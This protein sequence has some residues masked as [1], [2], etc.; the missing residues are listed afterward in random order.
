MDYVMDTLLRSLFELVPFTCARVLVPEGGSW[1]QALGERFYPKPSKKT[2]GSPLHLNSD[3]SLFLQR[4][5]SEQRPLLLSDTKLQQD[6]E[7]FKGH[8]DSRSW[9][10]VPLIASEQYLGFLSIGHTEPNRFTEEHLRRA[11]LLAVPAAAA[12]QNARLYQTAQIYG[13][14]LE[15]RVADLKHAQVALAESEGWRRL[16][17]EKFQKV[18]RS[19]PVALSITTLTEGRFLDVNAAFEQRYG[20][21][22][23]EIIGHTVCELRIWEDP[24][25]GHS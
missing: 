9:M 18:F 14:E 8:E 21:A 10:S 4:I 11:Q 25:T 2:S 15:K 19:S 6:W 12:I 22:R 1:V 24:P 17:E 7:N 13:T 16:T 3:E 20:Y 23:E 5:L